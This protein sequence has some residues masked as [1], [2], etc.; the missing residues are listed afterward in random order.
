MVHGAG[1][2]GWEWAR[3][4]RHVFDGRAMAR[5]DTR[6]DAGRP[7]GLVQRRSLADYE[8]P[9]ARTGSVSVCNRRL[10]IGASLGGLLALSCAAEVASAARLV[11]VNPMPPPGIGELPL[12][13]RTLSR[14]E[15]DRGDAAHRWPRRPPRCPTPMPIDLA[16]RLAALARRIR[17]G[18]ELPQSSGMADDNV[19][20][21]S[22]PSMLVSAA[23]M[24]DI[25]P[26]RRPE[27]LAIGIWAADLLELGRRQPCRPAAGP[28]RRRTPQ[29]RVL[30]W[31]RLAKLN[32]CFDRFASRQGGPI[33]SE[34]RAPTPASCHHARC[35]A[36][37][38]TSMRALL[39]S[40]SLAH[41][42]PCFE[43][44]PLPVI[45]TMAPEYDMSRGSSRSIRSS[46]TST[47]RCHRKS[48][49]TSRSNATSRVI[50]MK[51]VAIATTP[52]PP[53]SV[54]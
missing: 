47:S 19:A 9:G 54:P 34:F 41:P 28:R 38:E 37:G 3:C 43:Q 13:Q 36:T 25:H 18:D 33:Q 45:K 48:A 40:V 16:S 1:G 50:V 29:T 22:R 39:K 14:S 17:R 32:R 46:N 7:G 26:R 12:L 21:V 23:K 44:A 15:I 24:R 8:R 51:T 52:V 30:A 10:I 5:V 35:H 20:D 2:G 11:L 6:P 42:G 27:Q 31:S 49:G 4:G 53:C